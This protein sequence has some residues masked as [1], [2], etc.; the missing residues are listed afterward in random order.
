MSLFIT[1]A[2]VYRLNPPVGSPAE[3]GVVIS[4]SGTYACGAYQDTPLLRPWTHT[5]E[6][7]IDTD[8]RDSYPG[9]AGAWLLGN[10]D[11]VVIPSG[12]TTHYVVIFVEEYVNP[13]G[14]QVKRVY[15][16][17]LLPVWPNL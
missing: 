14:D 2:D 12:G 3:V 13:V 15:L 17:R 1:S 6:F 11:T 10:A 7:P 5:A 8:V 4:L 9:Q 16:D